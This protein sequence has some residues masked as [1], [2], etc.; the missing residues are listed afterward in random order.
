VVS[1]TA[2]HETIVWPAATSNTVFAVDLAFMGEN[3]V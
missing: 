2:A 3:D 1:L